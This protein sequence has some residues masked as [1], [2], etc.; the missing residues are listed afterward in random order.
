MRDKLF[1]LAEI[2]ESVFMDPIQFIDLWESGKVVWKGYRQ[3]FS[4]VSAISISISL[5]HI[6]ENF[7]FRLF[8][9]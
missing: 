9:Q 3:F 1:R 4:I 8:L 5:L 2:L 6:V 7:I